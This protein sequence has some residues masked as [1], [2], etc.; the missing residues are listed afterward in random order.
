MRVVVVATAA[1]SG[2]ALTILRSLHAFAS[3]TPG[4]NQWLFVVSVSDLPESQDVSVLS[5]PWTKKSWL[6]RFCFDAFAG[7]GITDSWKPDVLV[8][9]QDTAPWRTDVPTIVYAHQPV[10]FQSEMRFSLLRRDERTL[11]VYQHVIGR[12]AKRQMSLAAAVVVQ[13]RWMREAVIE[14]TKAT[15]DMVTVLQPELPELPQ[16]QSGPF[17]SRLFVCPTSDVLYKNNALVSQACAIVDRD[18]YKDFKVEMTISRSVASPFVHSVGQLPRDEMLRRLGIG[19]LVFPSRIESYG[20]PLAEARALGVPVLAADLPYAREVLE[21]Y[22][23]ALFFSPHSP[24]QLADCMKRVADGELTRK[25]PPSNP[26]TR[27]GGWHELPGVLESAVAAG[28]RA[29]IG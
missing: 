26:A 9:L 22:E 3:A 13:T 6:H 25:C 24:R 5:L 15:P 1:R 17:D 2:G 16:A 11:A 27:P 19:T 10:P 7:K 20:L 4:G 14:Q 23:N 12:L 28:S 29:G 8:T 18:G 21:G